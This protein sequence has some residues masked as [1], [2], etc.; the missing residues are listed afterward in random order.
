MKKQFKAYAAVWAIAFAVFNAI[1]FIVPD[2][3][4]K[5]PKYGGAF[6]SGYVLIVLAFIGQLVVS[7]LFLKNKN[8]ERVFL[9]LSLFSWSMSA[10]IVSLI[11][12]TALMIIP[13]VPQWVGAIIALLIL[14]FYSIAVILSKTAAGI[15]YSVGEEAAAE[16]AFIKNLTVKAEALIPKARSAEAKVAVT[17]VYEALRYSNKSSHAGLEATEQEISAK[18]GLFSAAVAAGDEEEI[19]ALGEQLEELIKERDLLSKSAK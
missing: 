5:Y 19:K 16:T 13:N 9:S 3:S 10:L 14:G 6:W 12:G 15:V 11:V 17:K 18:F 8:R 4:E 1:V 2:L 7:Y